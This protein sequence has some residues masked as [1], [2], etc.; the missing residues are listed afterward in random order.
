MAVITT[1]MMTH[2]TMK[3]LDASSQGDA[4]G[5]VRVYDTANRGTLPTTKLAYIEPMRVMEKVKYGVTGNTTLWKLI[6][7]SNPSLTVQ[8]QVEFTDADGEEHVARV[9]EKSINVANMSQVWRV[10]VE[11]AENQL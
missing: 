7:F 11:E 1:T 9:F 2:I 6:F 5:Q 8:D 10:V 4:G 3:R